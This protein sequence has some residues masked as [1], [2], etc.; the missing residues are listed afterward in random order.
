M[1]DTAQL[2]K[3]EELL[4]H[5]LTLE[6]KSREQAYAKLAG[7]KEKI[8]EI[9]KANSEN[10]ETIR[11]RVAELDLLHDIAFY[12]AQDP[13]TPTFLNAFLNSV[14]RHSNW[15]CGH[16]FFPKK[17]DSE[18]EYLVSSDIWYWQEDFEAT[19][20][21]EATK[22]LTFAPGEGVPGQALSKGTVVYQEN[23]D[24]QDDNPR[25]NLYR[26]LGLKTSFA[27]AV[28]AFG[29]IVAVTEF[30]S[31]E[32]LNRDEKFIRNI[33]TAALQLGCGIDR[34]E[35]EVQLRQNIEQLERA[36]D[37]LRSAK[38]QLV[39]SEKLVSIGQLAAGV[40][41]EINNPIG[42]VMS[43][44]NSIRDYLG[45]FISTF[46]SYQSL[47]EAVSK[48][49]QAE[50]NNALAHVKEKV[51]SEDLDFVVSDA[52]DIIEESVQGMLRVKDIVDGL[53]TF[54]RTDKT[55]VQEANV[56][57]IIDVSLKMVSYELKYKCEVK[58]DFGDIPMILCNSGKL[59]Q[60]LTNL[61][62]NASHAIDEN[63]TIT[64]ATYPHNG[65]VKI[66]VA[67]TGCG[68]EQEK[69]SEIFNPFFTTKPVGQGTGLGLSVSYGIVQEHGGTI[70]VDSE[71]GVGTTFT[72]I[73][74][75]E[76]PNSIS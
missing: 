70:E 14:C 75:S 74:P 40:A 62:V 30:F 67:D 21:I 8:V 16:V 71:V 61:M 76:P 34:R 66:T 55:T 26:D 17:D 9:E 4:E 53:K 25:A 50:I 12:A 60:V 24:Q 43:N 49:D 22:E 48:N 5:A 13:D 38:D 58:K 6:R 33:E 31:S 2:S 65:G 72:I 7:W 45:Q 15:P 52:S 41:H 32:D 10:L 44:V 37:D 39:Q 19:S 47:A 64:V 18:N 28:R 20:L 27:I 73:L 46:E 1:S 51:E 68:I 35:S 54:A 69:I 29:K 42:F 11:S 56:N 59:S 36:N 23:I 57:D 63:G 3:Q